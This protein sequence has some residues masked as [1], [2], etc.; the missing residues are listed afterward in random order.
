MNGT[1]ARP[2]PPNTRVRPAEGQ[3]LHR[4]Q[5]ELISPRSGTNAAETLASVNG[6]EAAVRASEG[7]IAAAQ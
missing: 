2:R 4:V 1:V 5:Q 7:S 3:P 6:S